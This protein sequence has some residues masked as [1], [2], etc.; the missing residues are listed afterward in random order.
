[1]TW[2]AGKGFPVR[3]SVAFPFRTVQ[4]REPPPSPIDADSP[5][6]CVRV[7]GANATKVNARSVCHQLVC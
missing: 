5:V 7:G 6:V 4:E 1:M 2:S 3:G